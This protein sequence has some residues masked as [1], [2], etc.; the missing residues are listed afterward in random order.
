[1]SACLTEERIAVAMPCRDA[2]PRALV[3]VPPVASPP[4]FYYG[5][6]MLAISMLT[7]VASSPGQTFGISILNEPMRASL[8]LSHGQMAAAY[9]L[10]TLFGAIPIAFIGT[11]M[12]R[13]GLRRTL[14]ASI[15]L[16]TGACFVAAAAQGWVTVLLAFLMLRSLG[17][18]ALAFLSGN[19]LAFWFDRRLGMVEGLRA[20]G[21]AVAMI[22][23]PMMNFWLIDLGGWRGAY[24]TLG[25]LVSLLLF[26]IIFRYYRDTPEEVGQRIDGLPSPPVAPHHPEVSSIPWGLTLKEAL[27]TRA[28][29]IV[30]LGTALFGVIHT[31]VF[32]CLSPIFEEHG[33]TPADAAL[34]LTVYAVTYAIMQFAGGVLADRAPAPVLLAVGLLGLAFSMW[35]LQ[36]CSTAWGAQLCGIALGASQGI[37]FGAAQPLWPR[38]FGRRHLGKIRGVLTTILISLSAMG[39][40][41]AGVV[42]DW[43]GNFGFAITAFVLAPL[44]IALLSLLATP[45]RCAEQVQLA[46]YPAA[47]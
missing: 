2:N 40:L 29:W 22:G 20:L 4:R 37:F 30:M 38:Y 28:F 15:G 43:N 16:F 12:D 14:L 9:T 1:M 19:T 31:A 21:L 11:F 36:E 39:P 34:T 18:G 33:L 7:L 17:P 41:F 6:L 26:P 13:Y 46:V 25:V 23:I 47:A 3:V 27:A 24:A 32:F 35:L 45:P 44:P 5:W 8:G 10:G 42:K